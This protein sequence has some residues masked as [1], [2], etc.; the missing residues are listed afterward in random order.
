MTTPADP[1]KTSK[2]WIDLVTNKVEETRFGTVQIVVHDGH[3]TQV[4]ITEKIRLVKGERVV[5]NGSSDS[6]VS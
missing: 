5:A 3:V 6:S 4:E 2:L 1:S